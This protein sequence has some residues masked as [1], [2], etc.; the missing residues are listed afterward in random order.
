[1]LKTLK[2]SEEYNISDLPEGNY[3]LKIKGDELAKVTKLVK[4]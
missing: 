1:M 4:E 2:G 3:M